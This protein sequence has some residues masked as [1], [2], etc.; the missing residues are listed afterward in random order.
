MKIDYGKPVDVAAWV[1]LGI[2]GGFVVA[3]ILFGIALAFIN[4]PIAASIILLLVSGF[5][6]FIY[7]FDNDRLF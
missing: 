2:T 3:A 6:S 4:H 7:L 5:F 1:I